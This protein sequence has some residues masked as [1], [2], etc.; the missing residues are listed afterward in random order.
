MSPSRVSNKCETI[1]LISV[2]TWNSTHVRT[3]NMTPLLTERNILLIVSHANALNC[4]RTLLSVRYVLALSEENVPPFSGTPD[5]VRDMP[6]H[7]RGS[8]NANLWTLL[9]Q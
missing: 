6:G 5:N 8:Q 4:C 1:A 7:I 9:M 2:Y 3:C